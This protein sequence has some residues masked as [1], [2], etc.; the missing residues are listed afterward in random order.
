[1]TA[2]RIFLGAYLI[3]LVAYTV[4]VGMNHGWNLFS[5]F[6]NDMLAVNWPGQFNFDFMG[7]L[8]LSALWVSWRHEY[9]PAGLA[10]AVVAF[11]GGIVFLATYLLYATGQAQGD[12]KV[13]L[14]GPGRANA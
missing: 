9:T 5:V 11:F 14:M 10:L 7:F 12:M 4:I 6:L 8:C 1:M 3:A 13:L 2:F